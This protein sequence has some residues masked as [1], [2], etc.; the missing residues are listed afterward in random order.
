MGHQSQHYLAF[1][2]LASFPFQPSC[3]SLPLCQ[4]KQE[5]QRLPVPVNH[6]VGPLAA[7][8]DPIPSKPL[9]LGRAQGSD[10]EKALRIGQ[11]Q[12]VWPVHVS[13]QPRRIRPRG[14]NARNLVIA[15][16]F[17]APAYLTHRKEGEGTEKQC[18]TD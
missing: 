16:F 14:T 3:C 6:F 7:S 13:I 2:L 4:G 5:V 11:R 18:I 8:L 17:P 10:G 15:K 12:L 1:P 9:F